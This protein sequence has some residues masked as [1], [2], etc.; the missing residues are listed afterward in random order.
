MIEQVLKAMVTPDLVVTPIQ[1]MFDTEKGKII[2]YREVSEKN[3]VI[4]ADSSGDWITPKKNFEYLLFGTIKEAHEYADNHRAELRCK[5]DE[6]KT[7]LCDVE[8]V[9]PGELKKIFG[10]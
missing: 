7:F 3:G 9:F 4:I 6:I 2:C 10:F 8:R 5:L 1:A